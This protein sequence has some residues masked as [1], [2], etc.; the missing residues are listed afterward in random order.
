MKKVCFIYPRITPYVLPLIHGMAESCHLDVIY[1]K[2]PSNQGFS[3]H[4][5]PKCA[6]NSLKA[7]KMILGFK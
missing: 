4:Y 5:L 6:N 1:S 3:D 7:D 2:T